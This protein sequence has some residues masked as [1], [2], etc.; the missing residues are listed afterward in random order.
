MAIVKIDGIP[1]YDATLG[2]DGGMLRISLVD[3][4]AVMADFV[5]FAHQKPVQMYRI[6][7]EE[8][9]RVL[10]VVV[11]ADFPIYRRD[12]RIGEYYIIFRAD[13]IRA[14]AQK[15]LAEG[16]QNNVN[17]M[18]Q[19]ADVEDVEMVQYFIKGKGLQP[20]GFEDIADGS[21][22]AEFHIVDDAIWDKVKDGTYK[23]FSLEGLFDLVPEEDKDD[24]RRIVD[25]L[26]GKFNETQKP[27][28][29]MKVKK[30]LKALGKASLKMGTITTDKGILAWGGEEDLKEGD[31]VYIE[32]EEGN[33][34]NAEDGEYRTDDGKVINVVDGVVASINDDQA[35]V[36]PQEGEQTEENFGSVNT[37]KGE[38]RWDGEGELEAG[39]EVYVVNEDGERATP[40][41]GDYT[42]EDGKVI[43][44]EEGRVA[45][46]RDPEAEV[47]PQ[48][49]EM[50]KIRARIQE[51]SASYDEI[52]QH[53]YEAIAATGLAD[54]YVMEAGADWAVAVAWKLD[55]NYNETSRNLR[56][57]LETA[58]DGTVTLKGEPVEVKRI[59]VPIDFVSPFEKGAEEEAPAAEEEELRRENASLREQ[60]KEIR[61][62]AAARPAH[63]EFQSIV[64]VEKTGNKGM[65]RIAKLMAK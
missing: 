64:R 60:L 30:F 18:H 17:L 24:V 51:M 33:R 48:E 2:E 37:D 46:I 15:Y 59:Y 12:E 1:V 29:K 50:R 26:G 47:A 16:R 56:Y 4:P 63:E 54:F 49:Q 5:A 32:D 6:E 7:D 42:T 52:Y 19:G 61:K 10:G 39:V 20:E 21:L 11:R 40:E 13:T 58:E 23:G 28:K 25:D 34:T 8:Q 3:A 31:R 41:D 36:A 14:L 55:E 35:E 62:K 57:A 43:R 9:R 45:E 44:V 27:N 53:V 65:D 38:L 22:F